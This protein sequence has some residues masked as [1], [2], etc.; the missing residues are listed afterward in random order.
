MGKNARLKKQLTI[1]RSEQERLEV[2]RRAQERRLPIIRM[3]RRVTLAV[4]LTVMLMYVG[5][6]INEKLTKAIAEESRS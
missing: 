6:V 2:E 4:I 1:E 3:V 5:V